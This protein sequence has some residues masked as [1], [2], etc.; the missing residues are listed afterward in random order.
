M[1]TPAPDQPKLT[2]QLFSAIAEFCR[3]HKLTPWQLSIMATAPGW[4]DEHATNNREAADVEDEDVTMSWADFQEL[5]LSI[6]MEDRRESADTLMERFQDQFAC[7]PESEA[8]REMLLHIW[9]QT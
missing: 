6:V 8:D 3:V 1:S 5:Q 7:L 9:E 2:P 4:I